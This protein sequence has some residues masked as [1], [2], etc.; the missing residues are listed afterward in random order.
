MKKAGHRLQLF[1]LAVI[2]L[3]S[4]VII[5][6]SGWF[7][8]LRLDLTENN[9]FT[10]NQGSKNILNNI[11]EQV[12]V[13]LFFSDQ[14]TQDLPMLRTYFQRV[15][16]FLEE[17]ARFGGQKLKLTII[18]PVSFSEEEDLASQFGLQALP[19]GEGGENVFFGIAATNAL[20]DV[21][22]IPFLQPEREP[23]LEYDLAELIYN[24]NN[25]KK[26]VIGVMTNELMIAGV[27]ENAAAPTQEQIIFTQLK[28][29][30]TVK[31]VAIE[32]PLLTDI[33]LLVVIHPQN[34]S[35]SALFA[36][37]QHVMKG[38]R[39]LVFVDPMNQTQEVASDPQ[40][41]MA[42]FQAD[43]SSNMEK[44]FNA[45][46]V[47]YDPTKVVLDN[48]SA[49]SI[50]SSQ[51]QTIRHLGINAW[52]DSNLSDDIVNFD[53]SKIHTALAG[54]FTAEEGRLLPLITSNPDSTITQ[55]DA[56]NMLFN[57]A[58]LFQQFKADEQTYVIAAR[59][60]GI[61]ESA[62]TDGYENTSTDEIIKQQAEPRIILVADVDMLYDRLWVQSQNFFGRSV[63]SPFADNGYF[64]N[65][66]ADNLSGSEDLIKVRSRGT[67]HRPFDKVLS[68]QRASEK[69][70][71]ETEN[72]LRQQLRETEAKLNEL[73]QAKGTE[74]QLIISDAQQQEIDRFKQRK[75]EV[76]KSLREVKRN[77]NK[78]IEALGNRIKFINIALIP[79][80]ITFVVVL[81][82]VFRRH[83]KEYK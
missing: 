38:G 34:L 79:M 7:S 63:F 39:L 68:I 75:L 65:N 49:L 62:F 66:L 16:D 48:K 30:Y 35:D 6:E 74:S 22:V 58:A 29:M 40:N 55:V 17:L 69:K 52:N 26:P 28:D 42:Q 19:V 33:D 15:K 71:R 12:H 47:E 14:A 57:P 56:I 59:I 4:S 82:S 73:Q 5:S 13:R 1:I 21:E 37:D 18:D 53:L 64:V 78:D 3:L 77:L 36:I 20:D 31:A 83:R 25:P 10:I 51:G 27:A 70:Y 67:S 54:Y 50:Q 24:L 76:R 41:P 45:W 9:V 2:F 43:R 44:L 23:Y 81:F 60:N 46:A 80:L 72:K 61:V 8:R 11:D 32:Q